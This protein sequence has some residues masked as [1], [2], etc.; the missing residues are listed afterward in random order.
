VAETVKLVNSNNWDKVAFDLINEPDAFGI[1]GIG[2]WYTEA[3]VPAFRIIRQLRPQAQIVGP[4]FFSANLSHLNTFLAKAKA[5]NVVPDILSQHL[6]DNQNADEAASLLP[7]IT[8]RRRSAA[9]SMSTSSASPAT[10]T[11]SPPR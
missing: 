10:A 2:D 9:V 5:D 6:L 8:Y 4:G 11:I 3:W 1:D 7:L